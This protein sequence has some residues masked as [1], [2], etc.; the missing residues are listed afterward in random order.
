MTLSTGT[1]S[2]HSAYWSVTYYP[3]FSLAELITDSSLHREAVYRA[4]EAGVKVVANSIIWSEDG[5]AVWGDSLP[6]NLRDKEDNF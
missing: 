3:G 4:S 2:D 6:V 5:S 1:V